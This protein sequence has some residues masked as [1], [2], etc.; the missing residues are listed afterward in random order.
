MGVGRTW[1]MPVVAVALLAAGCESSTGGVKQPI[2][3]LLGAIGG[4]IAGAQFGGGE[5]QLIATGIGTLLGAVVGSSVG[6]SLD[7]ADAV[8]GERAQYGSVYYGGDVATRGQ[9][10]VYMGSAP[11]SY[12]G[13]SYY[14]PQANGYSPGYAVSG[15][16]MGACG[17]GGGWCE[18]PNGTWAVQ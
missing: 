16:R 7:R 14:A 17:G 5:G 3:G 1:M 2:G 13:G 15:S 18:R 9:V 11:S 8:Y 10:P 12:G 4:G 6:Q